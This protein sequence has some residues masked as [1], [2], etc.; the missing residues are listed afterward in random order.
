MIDSDTPHKMAEIIRDTWPNLFRPPLK[1]IEN[2]E[3]ESS[4]IDKDSNA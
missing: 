2:D 3:E 1:N 4:S